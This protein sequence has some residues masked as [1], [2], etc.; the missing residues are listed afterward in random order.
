MW[1]ADCL[2]WVNPNLPSRGYQGVR[3]VY[4]PGSHT[5]ENR[6]PV[7]NHM[8]A[9]NPR[10]GLRSTADASPFAIM[11]GQK[12]LCCDYL[13]LLSYYCSCP[14]GAP[15]RRQIGFLWERL[16]Q[17]VD[18]GLL[19]SAVARERHPGAR[20]QCGQSPLHH[21]ICLPIQHISLILNIEL[22]GLI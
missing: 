19:F 14:A 4:C 18:L 10:H 1:L 16:S 2:G 12:A 9:I 11:A 22:N 20:S 5:T 15:R 6:E 7:L 13:N 3:V 17:L 8:D 21:S